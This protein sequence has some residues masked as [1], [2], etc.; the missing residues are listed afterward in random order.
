MVQYTGENERPSVIDQME[1]LTMRRRLFLM[2]V[3]SLLCFCLM[4]WLNRDCRDIV[5]SFCTRHDCVKALW[6]FLR[7]QVSMRWYEVLIV[8]RLNSEGAPGHLCDE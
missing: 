7:S 4:L 8:A 5:R 3:P 2:V 1:G 6:N